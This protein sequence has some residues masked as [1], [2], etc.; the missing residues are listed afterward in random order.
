[1]YVEFDPP[2]VAHG[3]PPVGESQIRDWLDVLS[4]GFHALCRYRGRV[5]GHAVLVPTEEAAHEL[6]I[7]VHQD[8]RKAGIGTQVLTEVLSMA[9][10]RD[11]PAVRLYVERK[12]E[13]AIG[14]YRS[15]GFEGEPSGPGELEMRLALPDA[16]ESTAPF[17][18]P[19]SNQ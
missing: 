19:G 7:F 10:S 15:F 11:V 2:G 6:A 13:P 12:N 3:L 1:M 9:V 18:S 16:E 5:V 17:D 8:Y 14:L 4:A